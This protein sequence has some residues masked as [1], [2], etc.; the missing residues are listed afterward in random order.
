MLSKR[1][2]ACLDVKEGKVVKG[3]KFKNHKVVGEILDMAKRY[4]DQGVDELV[5][6]DIAASG[7]GKRVSKKWIEQVARI[8]DIP[9][10]VA[11]GIR[12]LSDAR[13][14]LFSG[15]DKISIN[16]PAIER[17]ELI[18]ELAEEFGQQ[19]IV[20]GVDSQKRENDYVVHFYTG[21]SSKSRKAGLRTLDWLKEIQTLGAGEIVL[22]CMDRDGTASGYDLEQLSLARAQ[23][24]IPLVASGGARTVQDF[25]QV[26]LETKVDAALAASAFHSGSLSIQELK[27]ALVKEQ[28]EVRR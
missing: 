25:A 8:L 28:V 14:I 18:R 4:R 2:I 16:T 22:N 23:I 1:I 19:C 6:Y 11:G 21:S 9:F 26:F 12:S 27:R 5:F 15:A 17:P 10:C 7:S 24:E 3:V 20:V 13:E